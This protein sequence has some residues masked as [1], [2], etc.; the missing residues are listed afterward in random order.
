MGY[1]NVEK[2]NRLYNSFHFSTWSHAAQ[3]GRD[4][5][6][7]GG[8]LS[9]G[10]DT[11][12]TSA[13]FEQDKSQVLFC[14]FQSNSWCGGRMI[15]WSNNCWSSDSESELPPPVCA[16]CVWGLYYK[17]KIKP[18]DI[19]TCFAMHRSHWACLRVD[20]SLSLRNNLHGRGSRARGGWK[21]L[22]FEYPW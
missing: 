1:I 6:M 5:C 11:A 22:H 3:E 12:R 7:H 16:W 15:W 8:E 20:A 9:W 13:W 21:Q 2:W 10:S 19:C 18:W 4:E 14:Q 17:A